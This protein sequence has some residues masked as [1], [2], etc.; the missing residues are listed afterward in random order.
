MVITRLILELR[1]RII[2]IWPHDIWIW[3]HDNFDK[4]VDLESKLVTWDVKLTFCHIPAKTKI[5]TTCDSEF[6]ISS[7]ELRQ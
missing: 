2:N 5:D 7:A 4:N 1:Y 3:N 6:I